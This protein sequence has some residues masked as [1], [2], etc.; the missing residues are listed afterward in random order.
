MAKIDFKV[1]DTYRNTYDGLMHIK[2]KVGN[3]SDL[4]KSG[5][6]DGD[7]YLVDGTPYMYNG[8]EWQTI[9]GGGGGADWN[10]ND[11]SA[12]G[13]IANRTHY[14]ATEIVDTVKNAKIAF[15]EVNPEIEFDFVLYNTDYSFDWNGD[16]TP[17]GARWT[18][19]SSEG[20]YVVK[21]LGIHSEDLADFS[22][23]NRVTG[24]HKNLS[25]NTET[26]E[27]VP[28]GIDISFSDTVVHKIDSKY[29]PD[30]GSNI[31]T[32]NGYILEGEGDAFESNPGEMTFAEAW[33][34]LN[35]GGSIIVKWSN[36]PYHYSELI[37]WYG[38]DGAGDRI[39]FGNNSI[40]WADWNDNN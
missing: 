18:L 21:F 12:P 40:F 22:I 25:M 9:G 31:A 4:P 35:N 1:Q 13:Y 38:N 33:S 39:C 14:E 23:D 11:T 27:P 37:Q 19:Q 20:D 17:E 28:L 7:V 2:G 5:M 16:P 24:Y 36:G 34:F 30:V 6:T 15:D 10:V 32:V 26:N 3:S 29:L 8:N